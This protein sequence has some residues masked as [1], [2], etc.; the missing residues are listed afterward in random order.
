MRLQRKIYGFSEL[1]T[2]N[3]K[4]KKGS[5]AYNVRG[6]SL[7]P[8]KTSGRNVCSMAG[9][10]AK[11]CVVWFSGRTVMRTTRNAAI[12]RTRLFFNERQQFIALLFHAI[13]CHIGK[14]KQLGQSAFV[15]LNVAS[16]LKWE[17]L[18]PELFLIDNV[19]YYDYTKIVSRARDYAAGKLP[20]NYHLTYSVSERSD[21]KTVRQLLESG[22]N[23]SLVVDS[24]Y[25]PQLGII[26]KLPTKYTFAGK[27]FPTVD[28]DKHDIRIP[29][30]D[31][32][33]RVVLLRSKGGILKT[34]EGV[35]SGFVRKVAGGRST[36]HELVTA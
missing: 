6:L 26:G 8:A 35:A 23:V 28:G 11:M 22:M 9:Y 4:L 1:L 33:G 24:P 17:Q 2:K 25:C 13:T 16:D 20:K 19:V 34:L 18:A 5:K 10:C 36:T 31:G 29:E 27:A 3:A 12:A 30:L 32:K 14:C 15:R 21:E 7:A